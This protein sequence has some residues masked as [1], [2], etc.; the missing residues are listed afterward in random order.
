MLYTVSNTLHLMG[1]KLDGPGILLAPNLLPVPAGLE[2]RGLG[3]YSRR[4]GFAPQ[5]RTEHGAA[6]GESCSMWDRGQDLC[7]VLPPIVLRETVESVN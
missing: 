1:S 7:G 2:C 3:P 6:Y 4:S 5:P